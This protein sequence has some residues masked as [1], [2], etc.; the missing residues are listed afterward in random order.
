[1]TAKRSSKFKRWRGFLLDAIHRE[2]TRGLLRELRERDFQHV[3]GFTNVQG[4]FLRG[5][6][7]RIYVLQK[8][9]G[10]DAALLPP[11]LVHQ[12]VEC[13]PPQKAS[14]INEFR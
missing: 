10:P 14:R 11:R 2:D 1:M 13:N 12:Q 8:W 7:W 3:P 9:L 5:A 4:I 6:A